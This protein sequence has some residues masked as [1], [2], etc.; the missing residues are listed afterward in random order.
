MFPLC[1]FT[2]IKTVNQSHSLI[3]VIISQGYWHPPT[4]YQINY[5]MDP[6]CLHLNLNSLY[7]FGSLLCSTLEIENYKSQTHST[8]GK[9]WINSEVLSAPVEAFEPKHMS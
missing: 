4:L 3:N 1:V 5:Y 9:K 2:D 8:D 6:Y 7:L